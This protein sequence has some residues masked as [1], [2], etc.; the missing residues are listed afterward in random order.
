M[1]H[2]T[3]ET[4]DICLEDDT[5]EGSMVINNSSNANLLPL[6]FGISKQIQG[7]HFGMPLTLLLDSGSTATWTNKQCL[8]KGIQ[9]Y[10]ADKVTGSRLT[11]A[12]ASTEQVCLKD[13][14]L[15]DFHPKWTLPK[16]KACIFHAKY[17][18]NMIVGCNVL[19]AFG[20]QLDFEEGHLV[21]DGV[22]I[23]MRES[24]SNASEATPIEHLLQCY[25]DH[26]EENDKDGLSF[27][28]NFAVE[29]LDSS[30]EAGDIRAIADSC[31]HLM[32]EQQEDL[33]KL[34]SKSD[35]L[36]NYKL[37]TFTN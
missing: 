16:L 5:T 11:G 6:S 2:G 22:S 18:Y 14:S 30:Y 21:C 9:G 12:F 36:F 19:R 1:D 8:P 7:T 3:L 28:N 31:T 15:S 25:L 37:K 29:I 23:S 13:F 27:D 26:N 32:P 20:V 10:T 33:F 34:L 35:V 4:V 17:C 24:P